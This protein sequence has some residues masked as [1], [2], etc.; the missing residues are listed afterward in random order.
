MN[1]LPEKQKIAVQN[2][3]I[4]ENKPRLGQ[5]RAEIRHKNSNLLTA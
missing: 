4:V 1:V 5:C 3:K 2:K